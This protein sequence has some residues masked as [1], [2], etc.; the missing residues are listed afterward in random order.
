MTIVPPKEAAERIINAQRRNVTELT[1][2]S[3]WLTVNT[4][5]R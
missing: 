4:F 1:I 5:L 2:P 3:H